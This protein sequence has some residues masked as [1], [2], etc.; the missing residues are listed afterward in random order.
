MDGHT[1]LLTVRHSERARTSVRDRLKRIDPAR[2]DPTRLQWIWEQVVK[3]DYASDDISVGNFEVFISNLFMGNARHYEYGDEAY[4]VLLNIIARCNADI[5]FAVWGEM[6]MQEVAGCHD[7]LADEM[8]NGLEVN[9]FTAYVPAF[10]KK[11]TRLATILG[12]RYE[13][14]IRQIFLKNGTY[15]N[16][17]V[18]GLLKSEWLRRKVG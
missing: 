18:Y 16:L 8:F 15:H 2:Y 7:V 9:R 4:I 17:Y 3:E 1:D 6:S 12:Y 5:H 11:M 14:E 13:G 10:N